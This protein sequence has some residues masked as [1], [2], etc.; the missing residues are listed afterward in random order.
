MNEIGARSNSGKLRCGIQESETKLK[1][2]N[3]R[4]SSTKI[5]SNGKGFSLGMLE[6]TTEWDSNENTNGFVSEKNLQGLPLSSVSSG[7]SLKSLASNHLNELPNQRSGLGLSLGSLT[8]ENLTSENPKPGTSGPSLSSLA[9]N[10]L[11]SASSTTRLGLSS[12]LSLG[13]LAA[14]HTSDSNSASSSLGGISGSGLSLSSLASNHLGNGNSVTSSLGGT[15][16]SGLSLSSLA[17]SHLGGG[18]SVPSL[19]GASSHTFPSGSAQSTS[20][21]TIPAIFGAKT[22]Q[23]IQKERSV[24]PELEIDLMSALKLGSTAQDNTKA[25]E[26][27]KEEVQ[28]VELT[29]PD[30][31]RVKSVLRKRKR[32]E[33]SKVITRKWARLAHPPPVSISLPTNNIN[34]FQFTDP[35]PDDIVLK[36]QSQS[37]AFNRPSP[38][39]QPV[40]A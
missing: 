40:L 7:L 26:E 22:S 2:L 20:Q 12:G 1:D 18:S 36:A 8:S 24:S 23:H 13:S 30:L 16:K 25:E 38:V 31:S 34:V 27:K 35:S 4:G 9:S 32:S 28:I 15:S 29:V 39:R 21:F 10:H 19:G 37:K 14:N 5:D 11:C 33:F 6:T 3:L 17:S